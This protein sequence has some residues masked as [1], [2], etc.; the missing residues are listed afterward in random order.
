MIESVDF[1]GVHEYNYRMDT[2]SLQIEKEER[3]SSPA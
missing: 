2:S 3:A 1:H